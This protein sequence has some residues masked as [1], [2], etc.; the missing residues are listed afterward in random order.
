MAEQMAKLNDPETRNSKEMQALIQQGTTRMCTLLENQQDL[1]S[2]VSYQLGNTLQRNIIAFGDAEPEA[3]VADDPAMKLKLSPVARDI[4]KLQSA[5]INSYTTALM[6]GFT[7]NGI[8]NSGEDY[9][10]SALTHNH[11]VSMLPMVAEGHTNAAFLEKVS[12]LPPEERLQFLKT[13][14]YVLDD[15]NK[16]MRGFVIDR[17]KGDPDCEWVKSPE[18]LKMAMN[19]GIVNEYHQEV[20]KS[21]KETGKMPTYGKFTGIENLDMNESFAMDMNGSFMGG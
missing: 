6:G 13:N 8:G 14:M 1:Q 9:L 16:N 2:A 11:A 4:V 7:V 20:N 18:N 10:G 21:L 3:H 15:M 12:A 19:G 17:L 5:V